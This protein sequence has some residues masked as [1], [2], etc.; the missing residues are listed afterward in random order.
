MDSLPFVLLA[1]G[2]GFASGAAFVHLAARSSLRRTPSATFG[3][4]AALAVGGAAFTN[5]QPTGVRVVDVV[6]RCS[7][8]F[9]FVVLSSRARRLQ[10]VI[11]AAVVAVPTVF[12][13]DRASYLVVGLADDLHEL[14]PDVFPRE[15]EHR[16]D[17]LHDLA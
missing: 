5:A 10:L 12:V 16:E 6:L 11:A 14:W 1:G 9:L 3:A 4:L 17:E 13:A 15:P 2:F 8:A 7:L